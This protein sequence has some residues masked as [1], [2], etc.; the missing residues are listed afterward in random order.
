M[1]LATDKTTML[2]RVR[3]GRWRLER[4]LEHFTEPELK[5]LHIQG[6]WTLKDILGHITFWERNLIEWLRQAE[7]GYPPDRPETGLSDAEVDRMN[8]ASY[9]AYAE[10]FLH[11]V[12]AASANTHQE[13]MEILLRLPE[14]P[15]DE[16]Y[17]VWP[18]GK[19]PW[20]LIAGNTYEHYEEHLQPIQEYLERAGNPG[21]EYPKGE[22]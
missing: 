20:Q 1:D 14:D 11:D 7:A 19:P 5:Q 13:L 6:N 15:Y 16:R 18:D 12:L 10:A 3:N 8:Q 21:P 17:H 2:Q 4:A 9:E 22:I